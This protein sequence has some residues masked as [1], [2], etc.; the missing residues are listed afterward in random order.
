MQSIGE[1]KVNSNQI[2]LKLFFSL[3]IDTS[4]RLHNK[5]E[6]LS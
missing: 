6:I 5:S 4:Y 1:T 2:F 3:P